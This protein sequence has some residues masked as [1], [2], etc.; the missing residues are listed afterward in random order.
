[1]SETKIK[2]LEKDLKEQL[3]AKAKAKDS[4]KLAF[5]K[6]IKKI[7]ED[8]KVE[9]EKTK[10]LASRSTKGM[11][12]GATTKAKRQTDKQSGDSRTKRPSQTQDIGGEDTGSKVA[13]FRNKIGP[14]AMLGES[15]KDP[16]ESKGSKATVSPNQKSRQAS[17][18]KDKDSFGSRLAKAMGDKRSKAQMVRDREMNEKDEEEMGRNKGGAI[19]KKYGM[20]AGGFTKRGGM[21]KKGY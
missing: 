19:K 16:K 18:P 5:T 13:G 17:L 8:L 14:N 9:R 1:M 6:K 4:K 12:Y 15:M 2:E 3:A 10:G 21:Y 7:R 20:R 11:N